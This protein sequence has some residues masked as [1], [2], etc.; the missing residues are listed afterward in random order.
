MQEPEQAI[1]N[2]HKSREMLHLFWNLSMQAEHQ[3]QEE[4]QTGLGRFPAHM[5]S[6]ANLLLFDSSQNPYKQYSTLHTQDDRDASKR[7]GN[8]N[9]P[10]LAAAPTTLTEGDHRPSAQQ[11]DFGYKPK[12]KELQEFDLPEDLAMALPNIIEDQAWDGACSLCVCTRLVMVQLLTQLRAPQ[13]R[14]KWSPSRPPCSCLTWTSSKSRM[15]LATCHPQPSTTALVVVLPPAARHHHRHQLLMLRHH[16][17]HLPRLAAHPLEAL[18]RHQ[19]VVLGRRHLLR[20][21]RCRLLHR[22]QRLRLRLRLPLQSR[23]CRQPSSPRA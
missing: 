21:P 20:H 15:L 6:V 9:E 19:E 13:V 2:P 11:V 3:A 14:T 10:G 4:E 22:M 7:D 12:M 17:R 8:N 16:R 1:D 18:R 23:A 5:P